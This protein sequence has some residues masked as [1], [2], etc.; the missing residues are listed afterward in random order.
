MTAVELRRVLPLRLTSASLGDW[1]RGAASGVVQDLDP[2]A[3]AM[4]GDNRDARWEL[5][6]LA[7]SLTPPASRTGERRLT[8]AVLCLGE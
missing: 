6:R 4:P 8:Q 5:G 7:K 1:N 2:Q 3:T